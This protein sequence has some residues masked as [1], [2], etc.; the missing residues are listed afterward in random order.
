MYETIEFGLEQSRIFI[1]G[2]NAGTCLC[3]T[4]NISYFAVLLYFVDASDNV[5]VIKTGCYWTNG[6]ALCVSATLLLFPKQAIL[7]ARFDR[8]DRHMYM[9]LIF[10]FCNDDMA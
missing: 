10:L 1:E 4:C 5:L 2:S 3:C 6:S 8:A 7:N 9:R